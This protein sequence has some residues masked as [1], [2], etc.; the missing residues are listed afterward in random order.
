MKEFIING[1]KFGTSKSFYK[2]VEEIFTSDLSW[3]TG[4]NLD[5]FNELLEGGFGQHD[6]GEIITVKWINMASSREKLS[7][8]LYDSIIE[9][10]E[11]SEN[12]IF[13]KVNNKN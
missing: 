8:K 10:L 1:N 6:E 2:Y 13:E 7:S 5:A 9:I 4:K 11:E 12:V 3:E